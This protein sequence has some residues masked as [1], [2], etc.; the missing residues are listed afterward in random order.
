MT[1]SVLRIWVLAALV[2]CGAASTPTSPTARYYAFR[3]HGWPVDVDTA[4]SA[5]VA[6]VGEHHQMRVVDRTHGIIITVPEV[7][8][9][10]DPSLTVEYVVE[11]RNTYARF[12]RATTD[13]PVSLMV[14]VAPLVTKDGHILP[15]AQIPS[16]AEDRVIDLLQS[17]KEGIWRSGAAH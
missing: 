17:V 10:R 5:A 3:S 1:T 13:I 4:W 7:L 9:A 16:A 2:G 12:R 15:P 14:V 8:D 11:L 6:V